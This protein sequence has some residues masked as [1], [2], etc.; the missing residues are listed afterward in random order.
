MRSSIREITRSHNN[1]QTGQRR[2]CCRHIDWEADRENV[3]HSR[4]GFTFNVA[5][6]PCPERLSKKLRLREIDTIFPGALVM[7]DWEV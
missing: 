3:K 5:S 2:S 4:A 7:L 6:P 1:I